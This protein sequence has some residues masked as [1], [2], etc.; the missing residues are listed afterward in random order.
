MNP[1]NEYITFEQEEKMIDDLLIIMNRHI[2]ERGKS[3]KKVPF[4]FSRGN[5]QFFDKN[6]VSIDEFIKIVK[7]C[8][9]RGYIE[10]G[11][12]GSGFRFMNLTESGRKKAL[13]AMPNKTGMDHEIP[14][15][16]I[17]NVTVN[18]STQIGNNNIQNVRQVYASDTMHA[19]QGEIKKLWKKICEHPMVCTIVGAII[20][21]ALSVFFS[22]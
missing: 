6:P 10:Y 14:N 17:G 16:N 12:L 15:I 13:D 7:I 9:S 3:P 21:V 18:G 2:E 5:A 4:D 1:N 11:P 19:E 8:L 20:C 22:K